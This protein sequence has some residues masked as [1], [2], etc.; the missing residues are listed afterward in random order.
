MMPNE[1][2]IIRLLSAWHSYPTKQPRY[3]H[4][5]YA[6]Y[7]HDNPRAVVRHACLQFLTSAPM[8]QRKTNDNGNNNCN[9]PDSNFH[10][11]WVVAVAICSR[12]R[13]V[14]VSLAASVDRTPLR[15]T[16]VAG[17]PAGA[18]TAHASGIVRALGRRSTHAH[19]DDLT[20]I[21][22]SNDRRYRHHQTVT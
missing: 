4:N 12:P 9:L 14:Y 2:R 19:W 22:R 11:R 8:A 7:N 1:V 17:S 21:G 5:C 3:F 18:R 15:V 6:D 10:V 16:T 13:W 20:L